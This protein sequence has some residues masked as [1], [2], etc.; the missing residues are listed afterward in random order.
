MWW[1]FLFT[2]VTYFIVLQRNSIMS[3]TIS[4]DV[5]NVKP[6]WGCCFFM[7][8]ICFLVRNIDTW[9]VSTTPQYTFT[10]LKCMIRLR[11]C[12]HCSFCHI[13]C[14]GINMMPMWHDSIFICF[15]YVMCFLTRPSALRILALSFSFFKYLSQQDNNAECILL[16]EMQ[17]SQPHINLYRAEYVLIEV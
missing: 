15:I 12:A 7:F 17:H 3:G 5:I 11:I 1:R 2:H 8:L 14:F 4:N 10:V 9:T 6:N 16:E 13:R